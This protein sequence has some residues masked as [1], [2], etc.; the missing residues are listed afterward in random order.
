MGIGNGG[1]SVQQL[2]KTPI[3]TPVS[4]HPFGMAK[5]P[6]DPMT[7]TYMAIGAKKSA[8]ASTTT[9]TVLG[10]KCVNAFI[11]LKEYDED[12][13]LA[14]SPLDRWSYSTQALYEIALAN[15]HHVLQ[16]TWSSTAPPS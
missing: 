6:F 13:V 14:T 1:Y 15:I 12:G 3:P 5:T 2:K 9:F 10:N 16:P 4:G 11:E 8:A 7:G